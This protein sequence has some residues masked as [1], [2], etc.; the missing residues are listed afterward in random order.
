MGERK[1]QNKYYPPD[2][3]SNAKQ[4]SKGLDAYHGHHRLRERGKKAHLGIIVIRF[5]MPYNIWCD[6]CKNHIGMGVRY[7]AEKQKVGNYYST[8][9][10]EFKM[11]CH[12]CDNYF[13]IKTDPKNL[14]YEIISGA[15]R[16]ENRWDPTQNEQ[17]VPETKETQ[18][19]LF[20]DAM[21]KLEHGVKDQKT[22][23]D[24]KPA[25]CKLFQRN[26]DVWRDSFEANSRLRAQFRKTKKE[27]KS[28]EDA[29]NSVL[30]RT[31]LTG[32][33]KLLPESEEDR[34][35]AGLLKLHSTKSIAENSREKMKKIMEKPVLPTS[36]NF[37]KKKIVETK[38]ADLGII[39]KRKI[40]EEK[41]EN[42][43]KP[44]SL[45]L[46]GAYSSSSDSEN[47]NNET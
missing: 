14:D 35:L 26:E 2:F 5:E 33:V 1:G 34:Q 7:N 38:V 24:A 47:G 22:A 39:K 40:E 8:P 10:Y 28:A 32:S 12:L 16:Q 18:R 42:N 25:L 41:A 6:G 4:M 9:I 13:I 15:R 44:K 27:M 37:T 21:Y 36:G 19:K 43:E 31:S 46:V 45:S 29:D 23:E 20:D 11:K 17:I 3:F 30:N